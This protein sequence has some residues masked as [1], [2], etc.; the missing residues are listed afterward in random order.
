MALQNITRCLVG[1]AMSEIGERPH[2]A[3]VWPVSFM[4]SSIELFDFH[5]SYAAVRRK[6]WNSL[7]MYFGTS[8]FLPQTEHLLSASTFDV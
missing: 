5:D 7:P 4:Q 3:I 8:H 6:S 2:H 1:N